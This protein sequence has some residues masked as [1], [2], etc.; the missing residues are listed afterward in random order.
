[1]PAARECPPSLGQQ[2]LADLFAVHVLL[3]AAHG[4]GRIRVCH[5]LQHGEAAE[6]YWPGGCVSLS[7]DGDTVNFIRLDGSVENP[8]KLLS[9]NPKGL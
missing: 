4:G 2:R 6:G 8:A 7:L 9:G 3:E 1:M 5:E